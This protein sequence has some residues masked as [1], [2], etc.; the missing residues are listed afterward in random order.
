[1][2]EAIDERFANLRRSEPKPDVQAMVA[3]Y[4]S[5]NRIRRTY[6]LA[7]TASTIGAPAGR[8]FCAS[9]GVFGLDPRRNDPAGGGV[10][11]RQHRCAFV[12]A[13]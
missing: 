9:S 3:G 5:T 12:R 2:R 10:K 13:M 11:S 8:R 4:S 7:I 6:R 1:L